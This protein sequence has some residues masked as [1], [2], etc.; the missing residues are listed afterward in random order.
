MAAKAAGVLVCAACAAAVFTSSA[1]AD[2]TIG[3]AG[4]L[5]GTYQ[6]FGQQMLGGVRAAVDGLNAKGGINSEQ[7]AVVSAD[8]QCDSSKAEEAAQ[9]LIAAHADVVIGHF[10]SLP[11][12]AAAKLYEK[13]NIAMLSPSATLPALTE[14]GLSNV[15]R[16]ATRTD[17][18]GAFAALRVKTK[19]PDAKLALVDDGS[20]DMRAI[21][22]RFAVAYGKGASFTASFLP[23]QKDFA[24]LVAKMKT[25]GVD[26][27]YLAASASDAGR[28]TAQAQAEGLNL[29]RYGPDSMLNDTFW[30]ASGVAGTNTLVSFPQDPQIHKDAKALARDLASLGEPVDGPALSAYAAVQLFAAAA[31]ARGAHAGITLG[32]WLKS[33]QPVATV[34]GPFRFDAK[35]DGQDLRFTWFSWNNGTPQAIAPEN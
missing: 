27:I 16:L 6:T 21:M 20:P 25:A 7:L 33:G 17:D 1:R 30:Q 32:A 18:Q 24:D 9:K 35:G 11:A 10:C 14:S 34:L 5:T 26:T 31:G 28:L 19:R 3:V 15:I 2:I 4:P 8:D 23:D 13:A 22:Q 12:L 29:K